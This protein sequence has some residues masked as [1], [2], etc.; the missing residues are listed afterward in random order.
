[1]N[2]YP[3]QDL[4]YPQMLPDRHSEPGYRLMQLS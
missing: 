2:N 3:V 1:M 4:Y